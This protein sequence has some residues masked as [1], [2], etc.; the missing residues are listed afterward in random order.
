[1]DITDLCEELRNWFDQAR[2]FDTFTVEDGEIDLSEL[3][4]DESIVEGQY[5]RIV[6][7]AMND[8]VYQYPASG[9]IDEEFEGAV[10]TMAVPKAVLRLLDDIQAW[11]DAYG[12]NE[13]VL[14][15]FQSESFGGYSYTKVSSNSSS[16]TSGSAD[17]GT[18]QSQFRSRLNR[19]RKIRAV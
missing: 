3:V 9:L 16:L 8:G 13:A 14:S 2:Y 15:P 12:S 1:M 7:S 5:F 6:G 19:W 17:Y 18:W 10:W 11:V 4:A